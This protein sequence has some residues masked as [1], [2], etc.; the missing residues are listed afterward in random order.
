MINCI[1]IDDEP[2]ALDLL[3][4]YIV[5]TPYLSLKGLFTNPF[6]AA[7]II[8]K[9]QVNLLFLDIEMPDINGIQFLKSMKN[10]PL[11]IFTTAYSQ[12]AVE[13]FNLDAIDY[14]LKPIEYERF[15]KAVNKA[16]EYLIFSNQLQ[17]SKQDF[18]FVKSDYQLV[19]INF[20]DIQYIESYDD[21]IKI[22]LEDKCVLSL[23]SL[24]AIQQKIPTNQFVRVHRSYIVP[25]NKI[26]SIQRNRIKIGQKLIP[27][28]E[29]YSEEF[30][31]IL[32]E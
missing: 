18:I 31:K 12:Y 24:K 4:S 19:K 20:S 21:Y 16:R 3:E 11:V 29:G 2:I 23:M 6:Q 9:E 8:E 14:L 7:E 15:L 13:G 1:A 30:Y 28:S 5:K 27:I 17:Q 26:E 22:Y 32:G 10:L 25:V